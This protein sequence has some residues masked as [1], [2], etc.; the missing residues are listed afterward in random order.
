MMVEEKDHIIDMKDREIVQ[1]KA[2][3]DDMAEEFEQMLQ[4]TLE[5]MKERIDIKSSNVS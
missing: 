1:L 2:K 4:Q 3:M 5:K